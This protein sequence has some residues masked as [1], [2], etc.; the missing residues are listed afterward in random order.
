MLSF[1]LYIVFFL[2]HADILYLNNQRLS[3]IEELNKTKKEKQSLFNK[4]NKM[5]AKKHETAGKSDCRY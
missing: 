3:A 5:E 1:A 2:F 4:I